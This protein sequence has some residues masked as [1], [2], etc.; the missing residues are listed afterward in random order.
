MSSYNLVNLKKFINGLSGERHKTFI[1]YSDPA[2]GK[3]KYAR[4]FAKKAG[5]KYLDLLERFGK[6]ERLKGRIDVF[7]IRNLENSLIEEAKGINLLI[8]DN[9]E[10]LLNTWDEDGYNLFFHLLRQNWDS[11]KPSY[12]ATLGVFLTTNRKIMDLELNTSKGE[13]RVFPLNR[14]ESLEGGPEYE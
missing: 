10:F 6:D 14:L 2:S 5:S 11:F 1:V 3:S 7:D 9:I 12:Q 13:T 8:V 4:Q